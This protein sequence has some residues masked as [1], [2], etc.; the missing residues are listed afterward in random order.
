MTLA[1]NVL[2]NAVGVGMIQAAGTL[3]AGDPAFL[4]HA[5]VP[6][7]GTV[8]EVAAAVLFFCDPCNSYTTGQ[9]LAV[10]GGWMAR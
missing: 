10:D 2:V 9:L 3:V 5:A 6:R 8:A 7:A 4:R 1:P